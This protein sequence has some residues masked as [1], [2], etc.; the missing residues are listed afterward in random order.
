[1]VVRQNRDQ[2]TQVMKGRRPLRLQLQTKMEI[3]A[4]GGRLASKQ[5]AVTR[6]VNASIRGAP[7]RIKPL[8]TDRTANGS[9]RADRLAGWV[10]SQPSLDRIHFRV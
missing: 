8:I 3:S 1:M 9:I 5:V 6:W 2:E 7:N 4:T 10:L